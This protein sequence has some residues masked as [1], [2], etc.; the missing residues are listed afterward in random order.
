MDLTS[1]RRVK[2][3][4]GITKADEDSLLS[5]LVGSASREIAYWLRRVDRDGGDGLELKSRI[6]YIDPRPNQR[7]FYPWVY[8]I[9]SVT[10]LWGDSLGRYEGLEQQV[11][12]SNYLIDSDKRSIVLQWQPF[13]P[14]PGFVP[15]PRTLR[16]TYVAG[17]AADPVLS[18]WTKSLDTGGSLTAGNVVRGDLTGSLGYTVAVSAGS[19]AIECLSGKFQEGEIVREYSRLDGSMLDGGTKQATGITATLTTCTSRSLA[20]S[21]PALVLACDRH[22]AHWKQNRDDFDNLT[23]NENGA[24]RFSRMDMMIEYDFLPEIKSL[25][26]PYKNRLGE[27][28]APPMARSRRGAY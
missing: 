21:H 6:E 22:I 1:L 13:W 20:E 2:Y 12:P 28:K 15:T 11:D 27:V 5:A 9:Q 3:T 19:I 17:L 14:Q 23:V 4:L 16:L 18:V 10:A 25:L 26:A 8:P 24:T 7:R